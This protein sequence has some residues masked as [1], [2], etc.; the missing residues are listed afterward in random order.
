MVIGSLKEKIRGL[1]LPYIFLQCLV[2]INLFVCSIV[3][4]LILIMLNH[5]GWELLLFFGLITFLVVVAI[6]F[7]VDLNPFL[8]C[9]CS[10][11]YL[12]LLLVVSVSDIVAT[13]SFF[14]T[15]YLPLPLIWSLLEGTKAYVLLGET[16]GVSNE[17]KNEKQT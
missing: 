16:S 11:T 1:M 15:F 2:G 9:C 10:I 3:L 6:K 14:T 17:T 7:L 8:T 13:L 4:N 12:I 5:P